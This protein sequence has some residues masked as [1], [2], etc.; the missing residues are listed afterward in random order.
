MCTY[1][2]KTTIF[3]ISIIEYLLHQAQ[4]HVSAANAGHLH[5]VHVLI[6]LLYNRFNIC[7]FCLG[8]RKVSHTIP[9][10]TPKKHPIYV[11]SVVQPLDKF[12]HNLKMASIS[13]RNMQL[14]LMQ[15][16]PYYTTDKYSCVLTICTH[17]TLVLW[18]M[19]LFF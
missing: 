2:H 11:V 15:Q 3:I 6:E 19:S 8:V 1:R 5:V 9:F 13:G 16:I 10:P 4:L 18:A 12:M 14:C 17:V 7:G